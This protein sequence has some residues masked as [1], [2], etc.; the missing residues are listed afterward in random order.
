MRG[1]LYGV[2]VYDLPTV[3]TVVLALVLVVLLA[4]I[5][6]VLKIAKID[7]AHTLRHE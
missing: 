5:L 1:V 2:S 4:T 3:T 7:P 6:P